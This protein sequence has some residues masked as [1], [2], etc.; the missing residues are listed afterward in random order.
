MASSRPLTIAS[1]EIQAMLR[2]IRQLVDETRE[3]RTCSKA[4]GRMPD[5]QGGCSWVATG[6]RDGCQ[7]RRVQEGQGDAGGSVR[8]RQQLPPV[9]E[10]YNGS[11]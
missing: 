5:H 3:R 8:Y 10:P 7:G 1:A 11:R 9:G 6:L 2:N 4:L